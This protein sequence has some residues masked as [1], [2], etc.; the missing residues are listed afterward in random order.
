MAVALEPIAHIHEQQVPTDFGPVTQYHYPEPSSEAQHF[1]QLRM[2]LN[3][4]QHEAA[5]ALDV[6]VTDVLDLEYGRQRCDWKE[7]EQALLQWKVKH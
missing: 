2:M 3:I 5:R 6:G 4:T 7:A 1:K